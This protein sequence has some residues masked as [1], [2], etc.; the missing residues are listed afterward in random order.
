[1]PNRRSEIFA[2]G[3]RD[4]AAVRRWK[5]VT[6]RSHFFTS[7]ASSLTGIG[8]FQNSE[9]K[10]GSACRS[11][12]YS[13]P[14][15]RKTTAVASFEKRARQSE[16]RRTRRSWGAK[17]RSRFAVHVFSSTADL[18]GSLCAHGRSPEN[19][20]FAASMGFLRF[21]SR[22]KRCPLCTDQSHLPVRL[23]PN[24]LKVPCSQQA[25]P[26]SRVLRI[27]TPNR[28]RPQITPNNP[29]F[30]PVTSPPW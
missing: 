11:R 17:S 4:G 16:G 30:P 27:F 10:L 12:R 28:I 15:M 18:V 13:A 2:A 22:Q 1:M 19:R 14:F 6:G 3:R 29:K 9:K 23:E 5:A 24:F 25:L 26:R 8:S 21:C 7:I 20:S